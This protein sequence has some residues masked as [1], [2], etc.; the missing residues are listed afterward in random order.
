MLAVAEYAQADEG[1]DVAYVSTL[2][3]DRDGDDGF[4]RAGPGSEL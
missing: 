2:L 1:G 3:E 4:V